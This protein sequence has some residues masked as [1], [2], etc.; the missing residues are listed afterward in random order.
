MSRPTRTPHIFFLLLALSIF[1]IVSAIK[2]SFGIY[3]SEGNYPL[4]SLHYI[5]LFPATMFGKGFITLGIIINLLWLY[6]ISTLL[7]R[8][9]LLIYPE[10]DNEKIQS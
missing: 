1:V 4:S 3:W 7:S 2:F 10:K 6:T 9:S 5:L 8:L